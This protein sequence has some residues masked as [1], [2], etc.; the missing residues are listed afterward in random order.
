MDLIQVDRGAPVP[1]LK[2]ARR[3]R[4]TRSRVIFHRRQIS[5]FC[6][7]KKFSLRGDGTLWTNIG[8]GQYVSSPAIGSHYRNSQ[9][10]RHLKSKQNEKLNHNI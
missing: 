4:R 10:Q 9:Q 6:T 2:S 1:F 5:L 3:L 8:T 7:R